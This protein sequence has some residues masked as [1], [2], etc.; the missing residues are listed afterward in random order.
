MNEKHE[1]KDSF[2]SDGRNMKIV[3]DAS[4]FGIL[5][6]NA[7]EAICYANAKAEKLFGKNSSECNGLRCGDFIECVHH[8]DTD[9]CGS[10]T[11]CPDCPLYRAIRS[12][13]SDCPDPLVCQGE[14]RVNRG[15]EPI[16]AWIK[17]KTE[18]LEMGGQRYAIMGIDDITTQKQDYIKLQNALTELSVIHEHAPIAMLVVDR[19][20]RVKK[21]NGYA[22]LFAG[23]K[24]NEMIGMRDGEALRCLHHLDDPEGCGF[25]PACAECR[26]RLAVLETFATGKGR[27]EVESWLP[28]PRDNGVEEHCLLISTAHLKIHDAERVLVCAQDITDRKKDLE[29]HRLLEAQY[30]QAQKLESI[31]RLAGGVA[32]DFNN[33]LSVILGYGEM[34]MEELARD[35]PHHELMEEIQQA[36]DRARHLTRQ[37]LAFSRKQVLEM[38]V[39]DVNDMVSG[40]MKLLRRII[41]EDI[42]L[43]FSPGPG[44][45]PVRA[46]IAQLEQ[47]LMNL[48]VNARGLLP[49][50]NWAC[51]RFDNPVSRMAC[52]FYN[53]VVGISVRLVGG[54]DD[55]RS[56][57]MHC[58]YTICNIPGLPQRH[59]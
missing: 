38:R 54:H 40:L 28:F 33:L 53:I 23:R 17:F 42:R 27:H 35:H 30:H 4:P 20:R 29:K 18:P 7:R 16:D 32:H 44:P 51:R 56:G 47:V 55:I 57:C 34:I 22:A 3:M 6:F 1:D 15:I 8:D 58:L 59:A 52:F 26:V 5:A 41:G 36:A 10:T 39:V 37:L 21:A 14:T 49:V 45:I 25:G 46:D 12:A 11:A 43:E 9:G 19:D 48:A 2:G 50:V 31:G 13:L 24:A